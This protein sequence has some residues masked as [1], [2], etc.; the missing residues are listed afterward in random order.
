MHNLI[1]GLILI[2]LSF[3]ANKV[4]NCSN[5]DAFHPVRSDMMLQ[6]V[7]KSYGYYEGKINGLFD[8]VSIN[9]LIKFQ[10]KNNIE[11]DGVVGFKTCNLFLK[12]KLIVNN[13]ETKSNNSNLKAEKKYQ[14][15]SQE[16]YDAQKI[17][18]DLGLYTLSIDGINGP[19]TKRAIKSFQTKAGLISD[20]LLGPITKSSLKKGEESYVTTKTT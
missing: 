2:L 9:A 14:N 16:I 18:K 12:K 17:L 7:L 10:S 11:A 1:T 19:A 3:P 6:I 20:G 4:D 15:Y 8:D 5:I 13:F